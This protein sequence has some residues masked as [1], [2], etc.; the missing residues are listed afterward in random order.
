MLEKGAI[1]AKEAT[2]SGW[3]SS[4]VYALLLTNS[5]A[6]LGGAQTS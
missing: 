6:K 1:L 4:E 3:S 5:F 2:V